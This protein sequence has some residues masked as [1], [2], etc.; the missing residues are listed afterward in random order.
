LPFPN[1]KRYMELKQ[2]IKLLEE[3]IEALRLKQ[4]SAS[5]VMKMLIEKDIKV[6]QAT[7]KSFNTMLLKK[8]G[9]LRL[10]QTTLF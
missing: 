8:N 2:K 3:E 5:P 7:T 1:W 10:K 9:K 4:K 6:K